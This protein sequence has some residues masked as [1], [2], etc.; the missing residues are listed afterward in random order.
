MTNTQLFIRRIIIFQITIVMVSCTGTGQ[1][2]KNALETHPMAIQVAANE[3]WWAGITADGHLMP[4]NA[5]YSHDFIGDDKGN[6]IQPLLLSSKG[7]VIWSEQPFSFKFTKDTI[8]IDTAIGKIVNKNVGQT[9]KAAYQYSS[10]TFFPPSGTMP[11][12]MLFTAPQYNTWIEL[13]YNQNQKDILKYAHGIINNGFPPGVLMIDDT[14]QEDYGKWNW[15][16]GR[17]PHPKEMMDELHQLG[18]K[19]MLW[20]CPFVSPDSD[21]YRDLA[22]KGAFLV[23]DNDQNSQSDVPQKDSRGS[24]KPEMVT[25]WN[26]VSA[27]LDLSN[28]VAVDW[29][30]SQLEGLSKNYGVDGFKFDA[31]DT[32]FYRKG[33]SFGNVSSN[34][35]SLLYGKIGLDYPF[36][37]YRAMWKMGGQPLGERLRDK[38]HSW[39]DLRKL[40][41]QMI[42]EGLMGYYFSCPDMIGG[43]EFTSFLEGAELD[44]ELIVRSAQCHALMPMMQFSVAPWRILDED[45]L[46]AVKEAVELRSKYKEVILGLAKE[47]ARTGEPILRS[48][49][50][51]YPDQGYETVNDQFM[52]GDKLLIAPVLVKGQLQKEISIPSGVWKSLQGDLVEGPKKIKVEVGL[53]DLP[54]YAKQE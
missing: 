5:R 16:P 47:A 27:V 52:M 48:M 2:G 8:L 12:Q 41:P 54:I 10:K 26:G 17:F 32:Q 28:P 38:S 31:G 13:V 11:D 22:S 50:Y 46:K 6:Q 14:W 1:S 20:M 24:L 7:N 3:K 18:F 53:N 43:G 29:F 40:V 19:V 4:L 45:H 51:E 42:L 30:K 39:E 23:T 25:W 21:V 9:L 49:E 35:Q 34:E 36:N 37:E 44:Q 33:S 15:H